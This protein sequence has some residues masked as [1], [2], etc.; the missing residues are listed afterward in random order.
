MSFLANKTI[1]KRIRA[2]IQ[3]TERLHKEFN[4]L[5]K[6]QYHKMR[7]IQGRCR[8]E[9][10][11]HFVEYDESGYECEICQMRSSFPIEPNEERAKEIKKKE[12]KR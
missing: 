8:H 1:T 6:Q 10:V 9:K 7:D 11:N 3:E 12:S 4:R 2:V 5:K